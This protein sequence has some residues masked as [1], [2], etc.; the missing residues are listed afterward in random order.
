MQEISVN[1]GKQ[2]QRKQVCLDFANGVGAESFKNYGF[3]HKYL[4]VISV[5]NVEHFKPNENCGAEWICKHYAESNSL[6]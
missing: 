3:V 4:E 6:P 2:W 5:N 1:T